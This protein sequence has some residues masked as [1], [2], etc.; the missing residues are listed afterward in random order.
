MEKKEKTSSLMCSM[1]AAETL[2]RFLPIALCIA[3]LALMIKNVEDND[4]GSVS[5]NNLGGFK[6]L[7]YANG[8]CAGYSLLS[9]FYTAVPRSN[10]MSL[11]R[12]WTVFFFDQVVTYVIL[13]GA[14]VSA[15]VVYLAYKGDSATTWSQACQV[16]GGFCRKASVSVAITFGAVACYIPLSFIS[17]YRLFTT[18]DAPICFSTKGLEVAAFPG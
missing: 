3:A 1:Y 8:I 14:T 11:R 10:N 16:F 5:Y 13:A 17:S 12:A 4:F 18:Y 6:Y 7:L 2:L 9:A 15:E